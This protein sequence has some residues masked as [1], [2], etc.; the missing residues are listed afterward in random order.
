MPILAFSGW[1][2]SGKDTCA[3]YFVNLYGYKRLSFADKMKDEAAED[4]FDDRAKKEA[5]LLEYPA[6]AEDAWARTVMPML[7]GHLRTMDGE[8]TQ[9]YVIQ[10][11][12]VM[13][14]FHKWTW[15]AWLCALL[16]LSWLCKR[17]PL[18]HTPRS[19]AV[20]K[21][22]SHRVI[23]PEVWV[24]KA[25]EKVNPNDKLVISDLR[26]KSEARCLRNQGAILIRL[27]RFAFTSETDASERD[28]DDYKF[29][30]YIK[31]HGT[32]EQLLEQ[33]DQL[34]RDQ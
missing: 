10:D 2:G 13:G 16:W 17:E 30:L 3:D 20:N 9:S 5:P 33:C 27:Q 4:W 19:I 8:R 24:H 18:Y 28:L 26:L 23:D 34:V 15:V 7:V 6:L 32:V 21:G 29:D 25:F 31:N 14:V 11:G 1:K 22:L 12:K